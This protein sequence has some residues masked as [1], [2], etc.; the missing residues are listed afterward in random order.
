MYPC[1]NG[2]EVLDLLKTTEIELLIIDIMMPILDGI[3]T[4]IELRKYHLIPIIFLSAKSQE[5][6]MILGLNI[7][8]D[9]YITKPF[10]PQ[11][12][13]A[14]VNSQ[15]RRLKLLVP[16]QTH[17]LVVG[18]IRLKDETKKVHVDQEEVSLTPLEYQILKLLMSTPERV[19]SSQQIY[20]LVWNDEGFDVSNTVTVHIHHLREKIEIDP[21][22]PRYLKI[23]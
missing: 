13:L 18:N 21:K 23:V 19:Y 12:L 1:F 16:V 15:L 17:E 10:R 3:S 20:E 22:H 7:G 6:D 8:A 2:H 11:E 14:R 9:D 4:V 5:T